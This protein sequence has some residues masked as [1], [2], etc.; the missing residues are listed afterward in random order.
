M[1]RLL[2][3]EIKRVLKARQ[4]RILVLLAILFSAFMAYLPV[5][6]E[7]IRYKDDVGN[8]IE[9]KGMDAIQYEKEL[10]KDITGTVT[11]SKVKFAVESYQNCLREYGVKEYYELPEEV[12]NESIKPYAPLI[13]GVKEVF[14][15][16]STGMAPSVLDIN[17]DKIDNYYGVCEEWIGKLMKIEQKD[18]QN[19]QEAAIEMYKNV[20]KPFVFNPGINSN[21]MDYQLL[22]S[23]VIILCCVVIVAPIFSSDYQTGAHDI[24]RCTRYGG[25]RLGIIKVISAMSICSILYLFCMIIY[26]CISNSLF[27]WDSTKTSIQ[28]I[29]SIV[30]L[31][32]WN[33]GTLQ[34]LMVLSGLLSA[35]ATASFTLF[36]SS[37][38]KNIII[39]L[40]MGFAICISPMIV[41]TMNIGEIETLIRCILPSGGGVILRGFLHTALNF[42]FLN[43]GEFT[44]WAPYAMIAF[45]AIEIVLF[46][47]LAIYSY[48]NYKVH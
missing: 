18:N 36:I 23:S 8:Q 16:P 25:V 2:R 7:N 42:E 38:C 40:S 6:F 41:F 20:K 26:I 19:A 5:T 17:P 27:G 46:L 29:Y 48:N 22:L 30:N 3:L 47:G 10:Q 14:A 45:S 24:L 1:I 11:P 39:T 35:L 33:V 44:M 4:T 9:L 15:N 31:G 34:W 28:M 12:Y 43:I 13:S 21:V 37:K 32:N